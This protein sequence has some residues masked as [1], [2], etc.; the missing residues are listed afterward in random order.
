MMKNKSIS[1]Y[2]CVSQ[3]SAGTEYCKTDAKLYQASVIYEKQV[4][5]YQV[6]IL[7]S[8]LL[9]IQI[10]FQTGKFMIMNYVSFL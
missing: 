3:M 6:L 9:S 7:H 8:C 10:Q 4:Q 1:P 2:H 5:H